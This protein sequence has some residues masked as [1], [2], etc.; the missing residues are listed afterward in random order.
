MTKRKSQTT[1]K[2]NTHS[3]LI[4]IYKYKFVGE[5]KIIKKNILFY[6]RYWYMYMVGRTDDRGFWCDERVWVWGKLKLE[7]IVFGSNLI[8]LWWYFIP[9][10]MISESYNKTFLFFSP[11]CFWMVRCVRFFLSRRYNLTWCFV[12]MYIREYREK[13]LMIII[14]KFNI[15]FCI[16]FSPYLFIFLCVDFHTRTRRKKNERKSVF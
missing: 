6:W 13:T 12:E 15:F 9:F 1:T 10:S 2:T 16:W 4:K 11:V 8:V 5:D 7:I 3:I 14:I